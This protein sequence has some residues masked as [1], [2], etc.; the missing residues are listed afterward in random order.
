MPSKDVIAFADRMAAFY[1]R[2]FGFPPVAG[3]VLGY[4]FVCQPPEQSIADLSQALLASRSAI[5]NAIT[6]LSGHRA[7]RRTRTAGQRA[8]R[9][10]IDRQ[11]INPTGFAE[12]TRRQQAA[13]AREALD[14]L[15][16][17]DTSGRRAMLAEAAEFFDFLADRLPSLFA[18]WQARRDTHPST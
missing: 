12:G 5:T 18:E 14:L 4:L 9:V 17:G 6:L 3:R 11:A 8:D 16:D 2:E 10:T 7:V 13:F 1:A 15:D